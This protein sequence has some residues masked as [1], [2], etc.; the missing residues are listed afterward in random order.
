MIHWY[1][2]F[3]RYIFIVQFICGT[4]SYIHPSFLS[5]GGGLYVVCVVYG[6]S[7]PGDGVSGLLRVHFLPGFPGINRTWWW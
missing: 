5:C 2:A 4:F 1:Y 3:Y 7:F 6:C